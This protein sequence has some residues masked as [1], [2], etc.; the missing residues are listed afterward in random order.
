MS[1]TQTKVE[2]LTAAGKDQQQPQQQEKLPS[3]GALDEDDEFEEF[4][5]QDWQ[6]SETIISTSVEAGVGSK[7][8]LSFS[9]NG[10]LGHSFQ[11]SNSTTTGVGAGVDGLDGNLWLDSWDDD[12]VED[13]FSKA[14]R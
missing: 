11:K 1:T 14:L 5:E 10:N 3:L 8:G 9:G 6:D 12:T 13:D 4:A 2:D 7:V